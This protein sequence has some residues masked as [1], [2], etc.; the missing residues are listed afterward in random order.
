M[1]TRRLNPDIPGSL[2]YTVHFSET[3]YRAIAECGCGRTTEIG[4]RFRFPP[5]KVVQKIERRGWER[6][7]QTEWRCPACIAE[8]RNM[9][10]GET[11][12]KPAELKAPSL[13]VPNAAAQRKVF[14]LLE[15]HF[16]DAKGQYQVGWSDAKIGEETGLSEHYVAVVRREAFGEIKPPAEL[17]GFKTEIE[18]VEQMV[19]DLKARIEAAL[20]VAGR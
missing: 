15:D 8:R 17:V 19:K 12:A 6:V 3:G 20:T 10:K 7:G 5:E 13:T 18:A 2:P 14:Q 4:M 1:A 16:D 9:R 11:M